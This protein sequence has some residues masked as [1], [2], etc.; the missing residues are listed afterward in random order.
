MLQ[1]EIIKKC[2]KAGK[3][4]ITATQMLESMTEN[5]TA[6]RAEISDV[7]NAVMDGSDAVML[8]GETA[9]GEYPVNTVEF[10]SRV[11]EEAESEIKEQTHHTIKEQ[12][13]NTREVITKGVWQ[14]SRD[15]QAEYI[16]AHTTSGST[17]RNIS[18][19]RPETPIIA[20][21]DK[22]VVE[23]QLQ[24]VWGVQSYYEEFQD[25]VKGMLESSAQRM[26]NLD[27]AE[28]DTKLVLSAGIPTSVTGTTNMMQIRTVESILDH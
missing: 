22:E 15:S 20:F 27:L 1:K 8:S 11:I 14:A 19:H 24:L 3:P 28:E 7:A 12:P 4:V 13:R 23:R 5:P 10:M 6:T 16:I 17:A 9:I 2:N 26:L 21:T 18:K 25:N